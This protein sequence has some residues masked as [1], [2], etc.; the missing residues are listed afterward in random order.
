MTLTDKDRED[1]VKLLAA[2]NGPSY[3]MRFSEQ[4]IEDHPS[5]A[6]A[7]VTAARSLRDDEV[8]ALTAERDRLRKALKWYANAEIYK[9]HPH[10]PAF[11]E[12][13]LSWH[14]RA[15]LGGENA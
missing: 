14:A 9:P 2:W 1:A 3:P 6:A 8:A 10:G 11:D 5:D 12:R 13:D 4:D 7:L 15:A